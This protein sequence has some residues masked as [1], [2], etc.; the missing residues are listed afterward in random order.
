MS[1]LNMEDEVFVSYMDES[2]EHLTDIESN[3][4]TI[5]EK[6]IKDDKELINKVFRAA[7]SIKGG[8]GF[9]NLTAIRDLSHKIENV[10]D[11]IRSLELNPNPEVINILLLA[12]DKLR[13][14]I[15][16]PE[17]SNEENITDFLVSLNSLTKSGLT[18]NGKKEL[19]EFI[20][21]N[22][23]DGKTIMKMTRYD[24]NTCLRHD[25]YIYLIDYDLIY[26]LNKGNIDIL[27]FY[28]N[29]IGTGTIEN[30]VTDFNALGTLENSK[31]NRLPVYLLYSTVIKPKKIEKLFQIKSD[32]IHII[33]DPSKETEKF[34]ETTIIKTDK[35]KEEKV[36]KTS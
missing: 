19:S 2:R 5:E 30:I 32:K 14:L 24:L 21:I 16:N 10:L 6:G 23:P 36:K 34:K 20:D 8:A 18:K 33:L 29:L 13:E 25:Q 1:Y 15:N 31:L 17:K 28:S 26:N 7:H 22:L 27:T 11:L 4:L 3:L 9:F 12:F 35:Q